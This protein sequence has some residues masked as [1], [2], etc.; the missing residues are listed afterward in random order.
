MSKRH[1]AISSNV[2]QRMKS[3][4]SP[5][6]GLKPLEWTDGLNQKLELHPIRLNAVLHLL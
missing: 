6:P 5:G 3:A 4:N 2:N 1:V